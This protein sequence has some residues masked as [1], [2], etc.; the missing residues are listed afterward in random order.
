MLHTMEIRSWKYELPTCGCHVSDLRRGAQTGVEGVVKPEAW[1]WI[2]RF[3]DV[4]MFILSQ[5]RQV[6]GSGLE[7]AVESGGLLWH[8]HTYINKYIYIHECPQT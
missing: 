5:V 2:F 7:R 8:T 1:N 6:L 4:C 3:H